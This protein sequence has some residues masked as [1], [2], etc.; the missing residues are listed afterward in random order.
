[1][2]NNDNREIILIA[3]LIFGMFFGAGN[4]IF[5]VQIGQ[6]AGANWLPATIG[7]L[8]TG[9]MVLFLVM[10]SVSVTNSNGIYDIAKP[11][12]RWFA[13][14]FLIMVHFSIGPFFATPRTAATAF[15]MGVESFLSGSQRPVGMFLFS[16]TLFTVAYLATVEKTALTDWIGKYLNP[17]FLFLLVVILIIELIMP[18]GSLD[19]PVNSAYQENAFFTGFINGYNTMGGLGLM[20]FSVTIVF[21]VRGLGFKNK[22]APRVLVKAGLVSIFLEGLL[23]TSLVLLGVSSLGQFTP[24]ANGGEAFSAIVSHYAGNFGTVATGLLITLTVLTTAMGLIS[25]F[26]QDFHALFPKVSYLAW[27][28]I[29]AFSSFAVAN[30]GLTNIVAWAMPVLLFLYPYV[31]SLI[32]LSLTSKFYHRAGIVYQ[33]TVIAITIPAILDAFNAS[34]I[35]RLPIMSE[36]VGYYKTTI[37]LATV[38]LGWVLPALIGFSVGLGIY[39]L[40]KV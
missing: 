34:L 36:I 38:G 5:P 15:S 17:L 40:K 2:K 39:W 4:L 14:L 18:M 1:M 13:T 11:V 9:S 20:A 7:F 21:A 30:V 10:L 28:R 23:Y 26:A 32:F 22:E 31:L 19:Q 27:L 33:T 8:M 25:S 29:A 3:S 6:L 12:S 16:L 35:G 24:H 37:P